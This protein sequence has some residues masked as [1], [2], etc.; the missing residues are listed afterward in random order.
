MEIF[1][2]KVKIFIKYFLLITFIWYYAGITLFYHSHIINNKIIYHSHP[3]F[4]VDDQGIPVKHSHDANDLGFIQSLAH[5]LLSF[6]TPYTFVKSVLFEFLEILQEHAVYAQLVHAG[7][8][9]RAP[10]FLG[11]L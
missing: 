8:A 1:K 9:L 3:Y 4:P 5:I 2:A 7:Y 6:V 11:I 10:P